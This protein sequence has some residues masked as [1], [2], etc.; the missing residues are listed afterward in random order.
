MAIHGPQRIDPEDFGDSLTFTLAQEVAKC[1]RFEGQY[2]HRPNA[3]PYVPHF[4]YLR[5]ITFFGRNSCSPEDISICVFDLVPS[6]GKTF[7]LSNIISLQYRLT[8][9]L[10]LLFLRIGEALGITLSLVI[11]WIFLTENV[12]YHGKTVF[13]SMVKTFIYK[14]KYGNKRQS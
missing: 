2:W 10:P 3:M 9:I 5:A 1:F 13:L 7:Q 4:I 6:A 11:H 12:N 8:H 14:V